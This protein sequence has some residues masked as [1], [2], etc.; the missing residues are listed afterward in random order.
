MDILSLQNPFTLQTVA[1]LFAKELSDLMG[2][3]SSIASDQ[4]PGSHMSYQIVVENYLLA[5]T[6]LKR[7]SAYQLVMDG[8]M[9][10]LKRVSST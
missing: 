10:V 9:K 5:V 4:G 1:E 6:A 8:Q 3:P 7:S 2:V